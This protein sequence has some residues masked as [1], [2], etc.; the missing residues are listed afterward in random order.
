[1]DCLWIF[2]AVNGCIAFC[3]F[4]L[5]SVF[6]LCRRITLLQHWHIFI[7]RTL[8]R[9][10]S[11]L[12]FV[13]FWRLHVKGFLLIRHLIDYCVFRSS[14]SLLGAKTRCQ[15]FSKHPF[16]NIQNNSVPAVVLDVQNRNFLLVLPYSFKWHHL[17]LTY[18]SLKFSRRVLWHNSRDIYHDL[19][20]NR[21]STVGFTLLV[22]K[23]SIGIGQTIKAIQHKA[24]EEKRDRTG[25]IRVK[26]H[27][28][29][30]Q[31]EA[32]TKIKRGDV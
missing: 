21:D 4:L 32:D 31:L 2:W 18:Y 25:P 14:I 15:I 3:S 19:H 30:K 24:K 5:I 26:R 7:K 11:L 6:L 9:F 13:K 17:D 29:G 8:F 16:N 1:M 12:I 20:F 10:I 23:K 28:T 27:V 22:W